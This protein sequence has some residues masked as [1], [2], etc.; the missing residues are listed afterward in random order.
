M[1]GEVEMTVPE[2]ALVLGTR[3]ALGIGLGLLLANRFSEDRRRSVGGT[4]LLAGAFGAAVLGS[5]LFGRPRRLHV[6]FGP[7]RSGDDSRPMPPEGL[8][9]LRRETL[10]AGD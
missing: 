5:Q 1:K 6:A 2:M 7:E 4:L 9:A 3:A 8:D 10:R